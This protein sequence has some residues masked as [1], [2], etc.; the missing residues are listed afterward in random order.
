MRRIVH[1]IKEAK[2]V[3]V[4]VVNEHSLIKA[5]LSEVIDYFRF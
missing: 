3:Q 5:L 4:E 1:I 2:I